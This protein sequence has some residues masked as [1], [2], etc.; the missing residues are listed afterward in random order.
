MT[1]KTIRTLARA[2]TTLERVGVLLAAAS[3]S[4]GGEAPAAKGPRMTR[5]ERIAAKAAK[6]EAAAPKMTREERIAAKAAKAAK[7]ARLAAKA[8]RIAAREAKAAPKGKA[9]KAT[10]AAKPV[11]KG[12]KRT[13]SSEDFP[14]V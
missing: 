1:Q 12:G 4:L 7:E 10:K 6:T 5:A 2:A 9:A 8:E 13:V 14:E 3:A 11:K